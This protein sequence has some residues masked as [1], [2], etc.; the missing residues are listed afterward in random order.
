M[1]KVT[2][3]GAGM[4]A[5]PLAGYLLDKCGYYVTMVDQVISRARKII[6]DRPNGTAVEISV[7]DSHKL[8]T[9]IKETD[10]VLSMVPKPVHPHVAKSCLRNGKS[11]LTTSYETPE[12]LALSDEAREKGILILNEMGEDPGID[13]LGTMMLLDNIRNDGGKVIGLKSFGSGLPSFRFNNNPIGYKF[14][15]DPHTLFSASQTAAAYYEKGKRIDIHGKELFERFKYVDIE[16][17]GTFETYPNKDC[18]K[19][20]K[21]FGLDPKTASFYRGLLRYPGYCNFMRYLINLGLFDNE[22]VEDFTGKTYLQLTASLV[23]SNDCVNIEGKIA[24]FLHINKFADF[25]HRYK[26]LGL[27]DDRQISIEEGTRQEVL[28]DRMLEKMSYKPHGRD[29]I[30][31][32]TEAIPEFPGNKKEKRTTTMVARGIPLGDSA[33]SRAVGLPIAI[34]AKLFL[35]G[36]IKAVGAHIPPTLPRLCPAVLEELAEF[37]FTFT[38]KTIPCE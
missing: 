20:M 31:V 11:M 17:L 33:M 35:E 7:T 14:S 10:V 24:S 21:H 4:M 6:G 34:A 12:L 37:D 29:M 16:D 15:W 18:R 8:D 1:K 32:H 27:M 38:N 5:G 9:V 30:I 28:L 19:Y 23:G 36:R 13:H 3:I 2:V 22:K 25:I 26:W